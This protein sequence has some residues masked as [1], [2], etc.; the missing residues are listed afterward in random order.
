[1]SS[2]AAVRARLDRRLRELLARTG[3]IEAD[4]RRPTDPDWTERATELENDEVLARLDALERL[5]VREIRKALER[6]DAGT[7]GVCGRCGV[8]IPAARLRAL[9]F[10]ATCVGCA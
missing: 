1:M 3:K 10:T 4:R 6:L 7:Y 8:R 5:E 2:A 9:P